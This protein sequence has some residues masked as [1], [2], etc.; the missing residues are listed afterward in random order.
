[1]TENYKMVNLKMKTME[2]STLTALPTNDY[3]VTNQTHYVHLTV[4]FTN[5]SYKTYYKVV[6][7]IKQ[8]TS[9]NY[10]L[11]V[12]ETTDNYMIKSGTTLNAE[13]VQLNNES[14]RLID[15][16]ELVNKNKSTTL[17]LGIIQEEGREIRFY[18]DTST[19]KPEVDVEVINDYDFYKKQ[20]VLN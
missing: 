20:V 12:E 10:P 6:L 16:T 5:L 2:T 3:V 13:Y 7:K 1:M 8:V 4:P 9:F 15:I 19:N 11:V 17:Y 14:Y 18:S